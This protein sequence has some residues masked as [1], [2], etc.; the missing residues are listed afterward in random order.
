MS[1]DRRRFLQILAA[2]PFMPWKDICEEA[3]KPKIFYSIP[4]ARFDYLDF[5]MWGID[6]AAIQ[7]IELEAWAKEIPDL[8]YYSKSLER[9]FRE[10]QLLQLAL[11]PS[12]LP[13]R[14]FR[15]PSRGTFTVESISTEI[16]PQRFFG[17]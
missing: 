3:A 2:A 12:P 10:H 1:F 6:E 17:A 7:A 13:E 14:P 8:F 15:V 4:P 5:K 11:G 16:L 9:H